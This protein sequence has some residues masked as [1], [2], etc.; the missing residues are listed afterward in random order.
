MDGKPVLKAFQFHLVRLK[1]GTAGKRAAFCNG[2]QFH[3]VRLKGCKKAYC[4][5]SISISIPFSTIKRYRRYGFPRTGGCISIP[6]STIK[7]PA[8]RKSGKRRN[9][10]IPFST[11]KSRC[12]RTLQRIG[13]PI[14]IPFSTIKRKLYNLF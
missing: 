5:Y 1:A 6:F 11:I 10:S 7:S 3:L 14:S 2:F 9:I 13:H 8:A 4:S 12:R